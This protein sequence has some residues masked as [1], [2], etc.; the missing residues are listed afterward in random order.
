MFLCIFTP[1]SAAVLCNFLRVTVGLT[2]AAL[3]VLSRQCLGD[4]MQLPL[5]YC[6]S[7]VAVLIGMSN[8]NPYI[9]ISK[10]IYKNIIHFR[11]S[12]SLFHYSSTKAGFVQKLFEHFT[13]EGQF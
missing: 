12:Y 5:Y 3:T 4:V 10:S 2:V 9:H 1:L 8:I 7:T 11:Q 13:G 6:R